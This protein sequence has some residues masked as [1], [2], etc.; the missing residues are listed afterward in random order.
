MIEQRFLESLFTEQIT[1]DKRRAKLVK[2]VNDLDDRL[3]KI[4]ERVR[5]AGELIEEEK[6]QKLVF[7]VE[8]IQ[9][10]SANLEKALVQI[11]KGCVQLKKDA[12]R[13]RKLARE[14]Q[15]QEERLVKASKE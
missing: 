8:A 9:K 3:E 7:K 10:E 13:L 14:L 2:M 4:E 15:K 1:V 6:S 12:G 11:R 5:E